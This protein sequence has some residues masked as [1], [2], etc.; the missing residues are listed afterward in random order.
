M[1]PPINGGP[2]TIGWGSILTRKMKGTFKRLKSWCVGGKPGVFH[3]S[4]FPH[5]IFSRFLFLF[6][7]FFNNLI[8]GGA[9]AP[10]APQLI[11]YIENDRDDRL[12]GRWNTYKMG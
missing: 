4:L 3:S 6:H 1:C 5:S 9:R 7:Y 2:G 11:L 8:G 10:V 12:H